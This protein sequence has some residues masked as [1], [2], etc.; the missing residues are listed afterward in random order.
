M[1]IVNNDSNKHLHEPTIIYHFYKA[2]W[3]GKQYIV[4]ENYKLNNHNLKKG[5][6]GVII[7]GCIKL[8]E[9]RYSIEQF[10]NR[11]KEE[12]PFIDKLYVIITVYLDKELR[13]INLNDLTINNKYYSIIKTNINYR[14]WKAKWI[15]KQ[16]SIKENYKLN[17]CNLKKGYYIVIINGF[18]KLCETISSIEQFVDKHKIEYPFSDIDKLNVTINGYPDKELRSLHLI[19]LTQN[20]NNKNYYIV[21]NK[22]IISYLLSISTKN[23]FLIF[24]FSIYSF[25]KLV[26]P[27]ESLIASSADNRY[28]A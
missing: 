26:K 24:H 23:N 14:F 19:D 18:I 10:V 11:H 27:I 20:N 15:G 3:L 8:C 4:K 12:Y 7:K 5:Y 17:I 25:H 6:Y 2:K 28:G 1:D 16:Y 9:K 13:D 21:D 22:L